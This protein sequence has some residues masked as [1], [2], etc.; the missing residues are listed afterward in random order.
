MATFTMQE[1]RVRVC[2]CA[3]LYWKR[4]RGKELLQCWAI[5]TLS[6]ITL[7]SLLIAWHQQVAKRAKMFSPL[8]AQTLNCT[9]AFACTHT[10][11]HTH[12]T[13]NNNKKKSY[14]S[15]CKQGVHKQLIDVH[16][17]WCVTQLRFCGGQRKEKEKKKEERQNCYARVI[18]LSHITPRCT[19]SAAENCTKMNEQERTDRQRD[20]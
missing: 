6:L 17:P 2:V 9:R 11:T 12:E 5:H 14:T 1:L 19:L 16:K 15:D 7:F 20:R 13:N 4:L 18:L 3:S 10:H 8:H